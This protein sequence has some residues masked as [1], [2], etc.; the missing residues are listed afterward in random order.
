MNSGLRDDRYQFQPEDKF[1]RLVV[2]YLPLTF[3]KLFPQE[4]Q[5]KYLRKLLPDGMNLPPK[6]VNLNNA[7]MYCGGL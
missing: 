6:K 4:D 1:Q 3:F 7:R 5:T 2:W